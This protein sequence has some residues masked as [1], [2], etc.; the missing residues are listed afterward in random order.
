MV[1]RFPTLEVSRQRTSNCHLFMNARRHCARRALHTAFAVPDYKR[2]C[3]CKKNF[4]NRLS[5]CRDPGG[6]AVRTAH[7]HAHSGAPPILRTLTHANSARA[8]PPP[9]CPYRTALESE[10]SGVPGRYSFIQG[11]LR[12]CSFS[13]P[14]PDM[15]RRLAHGANA[16]APH[17]DAQPRSPVNAQVRWNSSA[18]ASVTL[19]PVWTVLRVPGRVHVHQ[20]ARFDRT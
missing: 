17:A 11:I 4:Q 12:K 3:V 6:A 14:T 10:C 19:H 1:K 16:C 18:C 7:A 13:H 9:C 2:W 15:R 20:N 5:G 8:L